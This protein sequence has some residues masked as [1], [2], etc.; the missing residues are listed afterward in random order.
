MKMNN[1]VFC[2]TT[3]SMTLSIT[4]QNTQKLF[5]N[6]DLEL[7][8]LKRASMFHD[9]GSH[10]KALKAL[11]EYYRLKDNMYNMITS[12]D[13]PQIKK[14]YEEE[15]AN[16][17]KVADQV[18]KNYFLYRKPWDME[19]TNIPYIFKDIID[20]QMNPFGDPEWT[21][22]LNRHG[23]WLDLGQA[24]FLTGNEKYAKTFVS[25]VIS[26]IDNNPLKDEIKNTSW[27]RIEAGIR[28]ENWIKTFELV[29]SSK[30]TTPEF[31]AKFLNALYEHGEYLE[32]GFGNFSKTSNWG[33]L[34]FHGLFN[35]AVYLK[36]FKIATNWLNTSLERLKQCADLQILE[37]GTQWEQSPM[38]HNEV[39]HCFLNINLLAKRNNIPLPKIIE[40]KTIDMAYANVKWQKP[41]YHQPLLGDSDDTDTRDL[42]TTATF[43]FKDPILKSRAFDFLDYNNFFL[44]GKRGDGQYQKIA[45]KT[46]SFTSSFLNSS[47]DFY[48]RTGWGQEAIYSSFHLKKLGC[49]H[50]HDN[51]LHFTVYAN[52]KDYL[53]DTGRFTYV[54]NEWRNF[55]KSS[56]NHNTLGVDD[57]SNSVYDTSW[58]N[59][60]EARS[61]DAIVRSNDVFDYAEAENIAYRRLKDP[62]SAKRRILFLKEGVWIMFDSFYANGEHK[63]SQYYNFPNKKVKELD[64]GII[65]TYEN[66][67]LM[68]QAI[69]PVNIS[70][71]DSW[72]SPEYNLKK[73]SLKGEFHI[74]NKG[75]T[76]FITTMYFPDKKHVLIKKKPVYDRNNKLLLDKHAEAVEVTIDNTKY[77]LMV[78]HNSP[79]PA[80]HFFKVDDIFV[81]GEVILIM[82]DDTKKQIK[83]IKE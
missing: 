75:F 48:M 22:M 50:G 36:E 20:W 28:C 43:I 13:L 10:K 31:L 81:H 56:E 38:Y 47:G 19:K 59:I 24:Y 39:F 1:I 72:Y 67:N 78:V 33:V 46:P 30:H 15:T 11:L 2:I 44:F 6:L 55:F 79:I 80:T 66:N 25:Q 69:N 45:S 77:T 60:Y 64:N 4:A 34:E 17:I 21:W 49:G 58:T 12:T 5:G 26:W 32:S 74:K 42:M 41:N 57:M 71:R 73:H 35:L 68:V 29:K 53:V 8:A 9:N 7:S 54:D 76:S 65:T 70:V 63:Y 14:A 23:Y 51:L 16:T 83:I 61:Q 27:R 52:N 62:V 37:D 82:E 3:I 18:V 40:R